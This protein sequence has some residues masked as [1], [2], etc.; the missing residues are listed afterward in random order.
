MKDYLKKAVSLKAVVTP[1]AENDNV[2]RLLLKKKGMPAT[3]ITDDMRRGYMKAMKSLT[4]SQ[5]TILRLRTS[6]GMTYDRI[7]ATCRGLNSANGLVEKDDRYLPSTAPGVRLAYIRAINELCS[8]NL[9][10]YIE[11]GYNKSA[12]V[13]VM[14][15]QVAR[16]TVTDDIYRLPKY[17]QNTLRRNGIQSLSD[18]RLINGD[19]KLSGIGPKKLSAIH[20]YMGMH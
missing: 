2:I 3:E 1:N 13:D 20:A 6:T 8:P 5:R 16:V 15:N 14:T 19:K 12:M 7:A 9:W 17:L 11:D 4:Y 18:E 10:K